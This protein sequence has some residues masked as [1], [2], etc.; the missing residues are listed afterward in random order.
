VSSPSSCIRCSRPLALASPSGLCP[1]CAA[2]ANT[3]EPTSQASLPVGPKSSTPT[4]TAIPAGSTRTGEEA[5]HTPLP[6]APAGYDLLDRL[7]VG[8]MGAVY[9][10]RE[11]AAERL[12]AMKFLHQPASPDALDRF[13]IELRVLAR[14][15][16][17]NIV[18]VLASD[19]LRADPYFT[20]E[21]MSGG[22]L[23]RSL[24]ATTP[25]PV[26][27]AV[28]FIR[29]VADAI[30]AA[31]AQGVIHRDLKPSNILLAADGTPKVSDFGLAKRLDTNDQLTVP[32][33]ALGTPSY[34]PPEQISRKNGEIGAWSDVYGLGATLYHLLTGRAPFIGES[35]EEVVMQVLADPP[36]RLRGLRSDIPA[37]L[38]GIVLKCLE[39]DPKDRYQTIAELA[40]D[41]DRFT[42]GQRPVAPPLTRW[43]R[44][45]QWAKRN[46]N[47]IAVAT[48]ATVMFLAGALALGG[49]YWPKPK[50]L[51]DADRLA[52]IEK[53]LDAGGV[54]ELIGK[55]GRPR[56][57]RWA[58]G[59]ASLT[60]SETKDGTVALQARGLTFLE[61]L[62]DP[63]R[64]HYRVTF[65]LRHLH[66]DPLDAFTGGYVGGAAAVP[67]GNA[68]YPAVLAE[69]RE[70]YSL[71]ELQ[72]PK[73][74]AAHA[75][76]LMT[77]TAVT[78]V[79]QGVTLENTRGRGNRKFVPPGI[80]TK[81]PP[82]RVITFD[83]TPEAV[84]LFW[85]AEGE[86]PVSV[87]RITTERIA[88]DRREA[89]DET[90]GTPMPVPEWA[91]RRPLGI[92]SYGSVVSIKSV[93]I[94]PLPPRVG[95]PK[96]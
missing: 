10:A 92:W 47:T 85:S 65:I 93:T 15:E 22:S 25:I 88:A 91:P 17:P 75:V 72:N 48:V 18:R 29:T 81:P 20:M 64:N 7:G 77:V 46:R 59:E 38:E 30:T 73:L 2:T 80:E 58:V 57:H 36:T 96:P 67:A 50:V 70:S 71:N 86:P 39:K 69:F 26:A 14:L 44:A 5:S 78:R 34:M 3:P 79:G 42:A 56:W 1:E 90:A 9:L 53:E 28:Q 52:E 40:A 24:D 94:Q 4:A 51:T 27:D 37:A 12:V 82:W 62:P 19:F 61:L 21:H 33:G 32:S 13:L 41:L 66:A 54:V 63:R 76:Q 6:H 84:E 95:G 60:E 16:H 43:R 8:G 87:A 89:R 55:N 23:S 35:A 31:H 49:V 68:V 83:V 45:K 11:Q 74:L